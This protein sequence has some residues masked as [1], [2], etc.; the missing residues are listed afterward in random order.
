VAN[1]SSEPIFTYYYDNAGTLTAFCHDTVSPC[2]VDATPLVSTDSFLVSAVGVRL[3]IHK[4]T[5]QVVGRTTLANTVRLP[6]VFYNP[7]ETPSPTP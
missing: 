4:D 1:N 7:E 2:L 3:S 5:G 6:N